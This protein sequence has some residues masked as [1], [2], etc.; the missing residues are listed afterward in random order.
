MS[1]TLVAEIASASIHRALS[2]SFVLATRLMG[3]RPMDDQ[4]SMSIREVYQQLIMLRIE[5]NALNRYLGEVAGYDEERYMRMWGEEAETISMSFSEQ[6]PG[7][8]VTDDGIQF[9]QEAFRRD[10]AE[11]EDGDPKPDIN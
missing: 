6:F 8:V 2:W 4:A 7:L 5:V 11:A 1:K 3:I 9:D 10:T